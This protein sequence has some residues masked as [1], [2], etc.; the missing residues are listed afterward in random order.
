MLVKKF[1]HW[2][3]YWFRRVERKKNYGKMFTVCRYYNCCIDIVRNFNSPIC[4]ACH[5]GNYGQEDR[6]QPEYKN[7]YYIYY[8]K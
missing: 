7:F 5:A 3:I 6:M 8:K 2:N 1:K 4:D